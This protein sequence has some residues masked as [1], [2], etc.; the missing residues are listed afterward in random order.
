MKFKAV[1]KEKI[2]NKVEDKKERLL[3]SLFI[4]ITALLNNMLP[5]I[6]GYYFAITQNFIFLA[7]SFL[8]LIF[9]IKFEYIRGELG[10]QVGR[11]V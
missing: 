6:L 5:F 10:I 2:P 7:V 8:L 9:N 11:N 4:M 3:K 1:L